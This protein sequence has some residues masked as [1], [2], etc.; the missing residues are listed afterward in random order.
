MLGV[1]RTITAMVRRRAAKMQRF[2]TR[3]T[4]G[5]AMTVAPVLR[6]VTSGL[7]F[8]EGP[9]ALP[10]GSVLVV[11]IESRKL[12]R[13]A[14]DGRKTTVA[15][16]TGG[17]NGAAIGPDGKVYICNNG[18]FAWHDDARHGLRV[19]GQAEDY[20]GGRIER[21]DLAT[22]A[23]E[24]LYTHCDGHMLRGP[25]DL[26][27]DAHG[28]FYFTDLGK[29]RA[30]DMDRGAVYYAKADG[31]SIK[32]VAQPTVTANGCALSPDGRTLYFAETKSARL[33]EMDIPA[34][35]EVAAR[36]VA[37]AARRSP[38]R[39]PRRRLPALRQHGRRQRR[40]RLR[41]HADPRRHHR[42]QPGRQELAAHP[43]AGS[44]PHQHLL[45]RSRPAHGLRDAVG[46][47]ASW[48]P[49]SGSGRGCG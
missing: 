15:Q 11:E 38:A 39:L 4:R 5:D 10:D 23:I 21:V 44:V 34:P 3:N 20:S 9:V 1:L 43:H 30:R 24:T 47:A 29:V 17:P 26:V 32:V 13:I 48:S 25:N 33:W 14:G 49:S 41:R 28:G 36:A 19:T 42:V 8:P 6:E 27:F 40:Q 12:T 22:G 46:H 16:H 45:R 7:R 31:S 35:G 2:E 37:L 18:G